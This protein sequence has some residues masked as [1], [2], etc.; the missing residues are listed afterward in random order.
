MVSHHLAKFGGHRHCGSGDMMFLV[1]EEQGSTCPCF[2]I[3]LLIISKGHG[4][5]CPHTKNFRM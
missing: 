1:V 4:M 2:N 3:P 5:P